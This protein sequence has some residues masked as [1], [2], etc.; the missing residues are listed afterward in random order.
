M[1]TE[2]FDEKDKLIADTYAL[3]RSRDAR[4]AELEASLDEAEKIV[5]FYAD[6]SNWDEIW[7]DDDLDGGDCSCKIDM[8][9]VEV[10]EDGEGQ[11][12]YST[13]GKRAREYFKKKGE[14]GKD[15]KDT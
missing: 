14:N 3:L 12:Y 5:Y 9:D 15:Q 1:S 10:K 7:V 4:I 11:I 2:K 6:E 13:A 8:E